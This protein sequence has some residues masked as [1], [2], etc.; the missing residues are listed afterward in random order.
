MRSMNWRGKVL[1]MCVVCAVLLAGCGQ[2][3]RPARPTGE[4]LSH[5]EIERRAD[6]ATSE[7]DR[8]LPDTQQQ[9]NVQDP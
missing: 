2:Q 1:L 3:A 9:S 6:K 8:A 7:L 4:A 5:E